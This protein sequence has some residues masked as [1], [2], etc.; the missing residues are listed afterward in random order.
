MQE[1]NKEEFIA[2]TAARIFAKMFTHPEAQPNPKLAVKM[3]IGLWEEL[4]SQRGLVE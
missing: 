1:I 2:N 3:A 4:V